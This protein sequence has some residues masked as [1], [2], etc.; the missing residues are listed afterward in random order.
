M[1]MITCLKLLT[2]HDVLF[3]DIVSTHCANGRFST[4]PISID[5][6]LYCATVV[7]ALSCF[8]LNLLSF[9]KFNQEWRPIVVACIIQVLHLI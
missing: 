9:H 8:F 7:S 3:V 2:D 6:V 4:L 5:T 1:D